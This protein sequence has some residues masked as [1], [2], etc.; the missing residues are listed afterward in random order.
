MADIGLLQRMRGQDE[1]A[2]EELYDR[3]AGLVLSLALR[4]VGDRDLAQEVMQDVFLRCWRGAEHYDAARGPVA[5]WLM[6]VARNRAIDLLRS[7]QHRARLR[8]REPLMVNDEHDRMATQDTS[9]D[10]VLR[11]VLL[12][13]LEAL[14]A[15]QRQ[16]IA[17]AYFGGMTQTE[18]ARAIGAPLGTVKTRMRDGMA[19]LR[20][21]LHPLIAP[22][23]QGTPHD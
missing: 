21:E 9:D 1:R 19:R 8:E 20:H 5:G 11:H 18:I 23:S 6:G 4:I 22:A 13:A 2:L 7:R 12:A 3:Y 10:V 16:V 15:A 14:P 17:L